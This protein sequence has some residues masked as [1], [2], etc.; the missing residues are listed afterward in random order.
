MT[1]EKQLV[2]QRERRILA[3]DKSDG[4][5]IDQLMAGARGEIERQLKYFRDKYAADGVLSVS[6]MR[7][8]PNQADLKQWQAFIKKY[9]KRLM[10]DE[11]AKYRLSAAKSRAGYD[12]AELLSSMV[13]IA[14]AYATTNVNQYMADKQLNEAT[15][16]MSFNNRVLGVRHKNAVNV[17]D[18]VSKRAHAFVGEADHDLTTNDRTWLRTDKLTHDLNSSID[19]ALQ[20][21]LDDD[22]YDNHLFKDSS[23]GNRNSIP[24]LFSSASNYEANTLLR[25]RKARITTVITIYMALMNHQKRAYWHNVEDNHVC[26][27]CLVLTADSPFK[28]SAIP[29]RPHNGCRCFLVYF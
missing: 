7:T 21:G 4:I 9:G 24:A 6:E 29:N 23:A 2:D 22:Y 12:R 14:V 18:E 15:E 3:D 16:A 28:A 8:M 17:A 11:E 13:G 25:E 27:D 19:R 5:Y 10:T 20:I 1:T 26:A